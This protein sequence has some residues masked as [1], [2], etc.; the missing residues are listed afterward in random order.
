M[1]EGKVMKGNALLSDVT[2]MSSG[3]I[4]HFSLFI[5]AINPLISHQLITRATSSVLV[6]VIAPN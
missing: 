2:F 1:S 3:V 4:T 6:S 5:M